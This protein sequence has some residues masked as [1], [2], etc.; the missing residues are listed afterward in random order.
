MRKVTVRRLPSSLYTSGTRST[1][2]RL[3]LVVAGIGS[4]FVMLQ[5]VK[6]TPDSAM[7]CNGLS[8]N[9][10]TG[11]IPRPSALLFLTVAVALFTV[12][13]R[14]RRN[15]T[16]FVIAGVIAGLGVLSNFLW[17]LACGLNDGTEDYNACLTSAD[18]FLSK[19]AVVASVIAVVSMG[20]R[21]FLPREEILP[22]PTP[23]VTTTPSTGVRFCGH[24]G[25]A[26]DATSLFCGGCGTK[27]HRIV[28]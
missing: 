18:H 16:A 7:N 22:T 8:L 4:L 25:A 26:I 1:I 21:V 28:E 6:T 17:K 20:V 5:M 24:C 12:A 27:I 9:C 23:P 10:G 2:A 11:D 13:A 3:A 15:A 14:P 19:C